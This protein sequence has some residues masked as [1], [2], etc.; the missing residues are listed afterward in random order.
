MDKRNIIVFAVIFGCN[1]NPLPIYQ[2]PDDAQVFVDAFI[3]EAAQRGVEIDISN[4]IISYT[5]EIEEV[6]CGSC[7]TTLE[8]PSVQKIVVIK[9]ES[10]CYDNSEELEAL[11]FH[12]LG[13]C[14]LNR[15]HDNRLLQNGDPRSLMI[16]SSISHYIGCVYQIGS[17]PCD[18]RFKRKYYLDEL[19]DQTTDPPEWSLAN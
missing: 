15:E 8:D 12:E 1:K 13:H 6:L 17:D 3:S 4:L 18:L 5:G 14:I 10:A 19:F 9:T 2:V 11:I 7:N 16:F